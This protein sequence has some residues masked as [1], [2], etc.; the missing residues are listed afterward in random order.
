MEVE[1]DPSK[2]ERNAQERGLAFSV[3]EEFDWTTAIVVEDDR[4]DYGE[5]RMFALRFIGD[6]LHALVFTMR[7]DACRVI[8]LRRANDRE[9]AHYDEA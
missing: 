8:S 3:V 1:F 6:R 2:S 5:T 7:G 9:V 4:A